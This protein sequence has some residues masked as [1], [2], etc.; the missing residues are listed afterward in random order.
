[1]YI[2]IYI[3]TYIHGAG[4]LRGPRLLSDFV[5]CYQHSIGLGVWG[6]GGLVA[7]AFI[8]NS[9]HASCYAAA[10]SLALPLMRHATL[11]C[12]LLCFQTYVVLR[13]FSSLAPRICMLRY[14]TFSCTS[15]HTLLRCCAFSLHFHTYVML[16]YCTFSCTST[17]ASCYAAVRSLC[18]S[19]RTSC[20]AA[21][22][23][24]CTSTHTSCYAAVRSLCPSTRTSCHALLYVLLH[25]HTYVML[26]CCAF[27]LALRCCKFSCTST[28]T[29]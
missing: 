6:A 23:S 5:S 8:G 4:H 1:M 21:V 17:R 7:A 9:T 22:R 28:H 3:Y 14:C 12:V 24:L 20:Y 18:I 26:H 25:I 29:S 11:L 10:R 13:C 16:R 15:T 19:T 2:Y 27:S